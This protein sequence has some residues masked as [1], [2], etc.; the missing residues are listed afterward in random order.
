[1]Q[2]EHAI[3][4][5]KEQDRNG[6]YIFTNQDL[7][8]LFPDDAFKTFNA[9]LKRLV[10]S[11]ILKRACRNVYVNEDGKQFNRYAIEHIA[12][13]LRRGEYNYVSLES[14]LS[15]YGI[16]SQIP[17]DRITLMTT[18]RK[19]TYNTAYGVIEFTH[20]KRTVEDILN[21][22]TKINERPLR[23]ATKQ[24]ALRDLKRVGRNLNLVN[25][26]EFV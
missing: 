20:T 11:G 12:K 6:K 17:I 22:T 8:K 14:M 15:E 21:N 4:V 10:K 9:G 7:S 16:I 5:L 3:K 18:G 26:D 25:Q 13:T 2:K 24:A 1:M 19:G 23:M